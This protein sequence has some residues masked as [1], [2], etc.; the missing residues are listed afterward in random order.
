MKKFK[1][2]AIQPIVISL[3]ISFVLLAF[4]GGMTFA[5]YTNSRYA[6]RTLATYQANGDKFSSNLLAKTHSRNN[7][8]FVY[9]TSSD[10]DPSALITLCNYEQGRQALPFERDI[11]YTIVAQLVKFDDSTD[12]KYV[13]V[14]EEYLSDNSLT[15][16]W[17]TLRKGL[18]SKTL[19]SGTALSVTFNSSDGTTLTGNTTSSQVYTLTFSADFAVNKPNLYVETIAT[20]NDAAL[21]TLKAIFKADIRSQGVSNSWTGAFNDSETY[22]PAQYDG[23]NYRITGVGSGTF[24]LRWNSTKVDIS[25]KSLLLFNVTPS[26]VGLTDYYQIVF[27]VNSDVESIYDVQFHKKNI[28]SETWPQMNAPIDPEHDPLTVVEYS[29]AQ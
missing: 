5:A 11:T 10:I 22:T 15:S 20:P 1:I 18:T 14:D 3:I 9:T 16:Y 19:Q 23:Y 12:L 21:P 24:T 2:S 29:Y 17:V 28:V 26:R 8:K 27:S 7:V 6:Q 25:D 13:P 4:A